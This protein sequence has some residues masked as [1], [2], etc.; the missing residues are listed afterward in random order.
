[1]A[2][3]V[4]LGEMMMRF[5]PPGHLRLEQTSSFDVFVGGDESIVAASLA[6]YGIHSVYVTK[7]PKNRLGDICVT[8]LKSLNVDT[9]FIARGGQRLGI[10]FYEAGASVRGPSVIYD[11]KFSAMAEASID[12]FDFKKIFS[13][14]DFFHVSGITP[15]LS[16]N[17]AKI[18]ETAMA[19]AR[20]LGVTVSFDMNYRSKLWE[21]AQAQ[22]II[23]RLMPYVDICIGSGDHTKIMLGIK[24]EQSFYRDGDITV[25]GCRDVFRKIRE[26]YNTKFIAFTMRQSKSASDNTCWAIVDNGKEL[27]ESRKYAIHI[28]DRGGGGASFAAGMLC[29]YAKLMPLD[30]MTEFAVAA[31]ALKQTIIG[32][33]NLVSEQ[34]VMTLS[35][36]SLEGKVDR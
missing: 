36:G 2:T 27:Y 6:A 32:D 24:A 12:D 9:S 3:I 1:M 26:R 28:V 34:E 4:T 8:K 29:G 15:A 14:A 25:E 21:P 33:Y 23:C 16:E 11:R 10:N 30:A 18:A 5:M 7:L 31:C 13:G 35:Q 17:C 19:T 20:E 22:K